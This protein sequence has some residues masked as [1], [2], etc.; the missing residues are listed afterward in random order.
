MKIVK[1][2]VALGLLLGILTSALADTPK[3]IGRAATVNGIIA[4]MD[5]R[6]LVVRVKQPTGE[7]KELTFP[8]DD[9][10]EV[11]VDGDAGTVDDLRP[12][13]I[14]Q[15]TSAVRNVPGPARLV[16][17]TSKSLSGVVMRLDGRNLVIKA[18]EQGEKKEVTVETDSRTRV[19]FG[20]SGA[21]QATASEGR[22]ED[23]KPEMRVKVLPDTGTAR[24]IFVTSV[25]AKKTAK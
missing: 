3:H 4:R 21:Q 24:K 17:A 18:Q 19:F 23:I 7:P 2:I 5:G 8:T 16:K 14:V 20:A 11:R 15:I 1:S 25:P 6:D 9:N 12:D 13:M 22:L 10:T